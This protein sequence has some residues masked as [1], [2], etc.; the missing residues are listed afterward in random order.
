VQLRR[1]ASQVLTEIMDVPKSLASDCKDPFIEEG[2]QRLQR[3]GAIPQ[4]KDS[5]LP[6]ASGLLSTMYIT[7]DE[8]TLNA[9]ISVFAPRS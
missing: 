3:I 5:T 6:L 9:A 2:V 8:R 1:S 7:Q 4:A